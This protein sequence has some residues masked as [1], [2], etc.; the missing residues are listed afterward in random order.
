MNK[1]KKLIDSDFFQ[2][3]TSI[4][5]E[6]ASI[7]VDLGV[8]K[9]APIKEL[10]FLVSFKILANEIQKNNFPTL[11]ESEIL[12]NI[13]DKVEAALKQYDY[14]FVGCFLCNGIREVFYYTD[15]SVDFKTIVDKIMVEHS[16]HKYKCSLVEDESWE[17]YFNV[18]SP[19]EYEYQR[20][21]DGVLIHKLEQ[22]GDKIEVARNIDFYIYFENEVDAKNVLKA[23][24]EDGYEGEITKNEDGVFGVS[25]IKNMPVFP[26]IYSATELFVTLAKENNGDFDGWGCVHVKEEK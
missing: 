17:L 19:N 26:N 24:E 14:I 20:G 16:T 15:N 9:F 21:L 1:Y 2:Y 10:P 18:L 7:I 5:N 25:V 6:I 23:L 12:Y 8:E 11:E 22:S 4:D 13:G 3:N